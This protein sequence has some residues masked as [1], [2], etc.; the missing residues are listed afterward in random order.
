MILSI[1]HVAVVADDPEALSEW[2]CDVLGFERVRS[3][4]A[5]RIY[6]IGLA[7]G[8]LLEILPSNRAGRTDADADDAGIRHIALS[9]KEFDVVHQRLEDRGIAFTGPEL[10]LPDGTRMDFFPD[11]EGNVLQL[12]HRP[13]PLGE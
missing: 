1:E 9:V 5:D 2:Y 6:F 12:V 4:A 7:G 8:G 13:R 11:P 10:D 3:S